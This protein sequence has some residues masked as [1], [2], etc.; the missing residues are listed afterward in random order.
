MFIYIYLLKWHRHICIYIQS[1]HI[2]SSPN[3][4]SLQMAINTVNQHTLKCWIT[5]NVS[6]FSQTVNVNVDECHFR[7]NNVNYPSKKI[8]ASS[9]C[10]EAIYH[11]V[12]CVTAMKKIKSF[13][14]HHVHKVKCFKYICS[15]N[16][17]ELPCEISLI[18]VRFFK[19]IPSVYNM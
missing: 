15:Y 14:C 17:H 4:F 3:I 1:I 5:Y 7:F 19:K 9:P 6:F 13:K 10:N 18:I 2:L 16:I 11:Y 12:K 8:L